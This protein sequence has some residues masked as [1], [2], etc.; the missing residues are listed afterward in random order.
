MV[1]NDAAGIHSKPA[2]AEGGGAWFYGTITMTS[3][4]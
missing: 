2:Y 3:P 1:L 4:A